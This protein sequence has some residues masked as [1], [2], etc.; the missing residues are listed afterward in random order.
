MMKENWIDQMRRKL[1]GHEVAPPEGLWEDICKEMGLTPERV[2]KTAASKRWYWA[3]AALLALAGFFAYYHE[4]GLRG[5][6]EEA[7]VKNEELRI[8][9]YDYSQ[10]EN[11][12]KKGNYHSALPLGSAK[13]IGSE[14]ERVRGSFRA[15]RPATYH[16]PSVDLRARTT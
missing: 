16:R 6:N 15:L 2:R 9:S 5:K 1:E 4:D 3:V 8:K 10:D 14:R 7:R 12:P 11:K 13:N